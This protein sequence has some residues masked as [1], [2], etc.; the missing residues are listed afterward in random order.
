VVQRTL[1]EG[2]VTG[3]EWA[4]VVDERRV[5]HDSIHGEIV[6]IDNETGTYFSLRDLAAECWLA[7]AAGVGR[8]DLVSAV[9]HAYAADPVTTGEA[10]DGLIERLHGYGILRPC[11]ASTSVTPTIA[12]PATAMAP[13]P[14][15]EVYTDLQD[16]L[17]FDPIHEVG[18]E[19]WPHQRS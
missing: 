18:P 6:A 16:L 7:L 13:M 3:A 19:G 12:A 17:L 2:T 5:V 15:V 11:E 8:T 4:Y 1:E 9:A 10:V 14:V